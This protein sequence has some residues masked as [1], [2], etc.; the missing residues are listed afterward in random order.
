MALNLISGPAVE[1]VSLAELKEF[2]RID[3][4][5]SS[6]DNT[7]ATLAVQARAYCE[8]FSCRRFVQ[9][10]WELSL[11]FFPGYIDLKLAG[12]K[13]SSPFVS[14]SNAVLTG[15]RYALVLPFPPAKS[16]VSFTYQNANGQVTSMTEGTDYVADLLSQPPRLAPPF[17]SMWPVARVTLNAISI[18]W[19]LGY[20]LPI[21]LSVAANAKAITG[22]AFA[23]TDAGC[24]ISIPGAGPGGAALNTIVASVDDGGAGTLRDAASTAV[25][26]GAA[27]LVDNGNADDWETIRGAIKSMTLGDYERRLPRKV[28]ENSIDNML[29]PIRD[30]RL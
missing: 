9:Q 29:W 7:I 1:P 28:I 10:T 6:Q 23:A 18:Q 14:G 2:M 15:I 12:Q 21:A 17:G 13:V 19:T 27:L 20:A 16:I 11:D 3:A 5:D 22:Y 25:S 8:K 24:P 4:G 26:N 30:K